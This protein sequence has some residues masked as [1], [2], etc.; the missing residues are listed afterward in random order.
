MT[1]VVQ[2]EGVFAPILQR[3]GP[4]VRVHMGLLLFV[5]QLRIVIYLFC[6]LE[7]T[8]LAL[9]GLQE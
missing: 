5:D 1:R 4:C 9:F 2:K 3:L 8:K 7:Y 6:L